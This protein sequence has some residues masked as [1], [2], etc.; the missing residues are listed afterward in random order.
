MNVRLTWSYALSL[1]TCLPLA[2]CASGPET[3]SGVAR[4]PWGSLEHAL[5]QI[6]DLPLAGTPG[7]PAAVHLLIP[8]NQ[9]DAVYESLSRAFYTGS[10]ELMHKQSDSGLD[11]IGYEI[12]CALANPVE[13]VEVK[14][15]LFAPI[16]ERLWLEQIPYGVRPW[17]QLQRRAEILVPRLFAGRA[18]DALDEI[19]PAEFWRSSHASTQA[20]RQGHAADARIGQQLSGRDAGQTQ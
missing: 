1:A 6:S 18:R 3:A 14:A 11:M 2:G 20:A 8:K 17:D 9:S 12:F 15:E 13:L 5:A 7:A 4:I 10:Y 19:V 16:A